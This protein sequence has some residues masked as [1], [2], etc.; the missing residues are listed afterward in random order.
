MHEVELKNYYYRDSTKKIKAKLLKSDCG[1]QNH[2]NFNRIQI[3][4][5]NRIRLLHDNTI[6]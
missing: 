3:R 6:Y 2:S 4:F 1:L 5:N